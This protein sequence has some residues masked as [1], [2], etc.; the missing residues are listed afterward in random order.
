MGITGLPSFVAE[1]ALLE[2]ALERVL[3]CWHLL[4]TTLY[5]G[6][7]TRKHV[8]ARTRAFVDFL[9]ETFGGEDRDPWLIAAGCETQ[10]SGPAPRGAKKKL[11][12]VA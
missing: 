1:E 11:A 8:P 6:M 2:N 10:T 5:A 7:P 9:V 12:S 4:S 3:P